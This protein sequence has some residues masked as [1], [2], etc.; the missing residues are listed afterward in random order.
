MYVQGGELRNGRPNNWTDERS[1]QALAA[2]KKNYHPGGEGGPPGNT[3][4][5]YHC[6]TYVLHTFKISVILET[7][8]EKAVSGVE[9]IMSDRDEGRLEPRTV[10]TAGNRKQMVNYPFY[11][12]A[13]PISED[14][15]N[16]EL[17]HLGGIVLH[18]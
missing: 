3:Y 2:I 17:P 11:I 13:L 1:E 16:V 14:H 18:L 4:H 7:L 15:F 6:F 12:R 5:T 8:H 9:C 10:Q